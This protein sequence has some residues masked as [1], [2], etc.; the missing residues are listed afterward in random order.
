MLSSDFYRRK[1]FALDQNHCG[2][3][4][5]VLF[6]SGVPPTSGEDHGQKQNIIR[7]TF[8]DFGIAILCIGSDFSSSS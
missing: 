3:V 6:F 2:T 1:Q 5:S 8:L 7:N 4:R